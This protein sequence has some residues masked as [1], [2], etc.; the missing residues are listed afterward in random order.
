MD[1]YLTVAVEAAY[2]AGDIII[3]SMGQFDTVQAIQKGLN[4]WITAV[5]HA[6]EKVIIETLL[7]TYPNH[8]ILAEESGLQEGNAFTWIIDPLDGTRNYVHGFPQFAVSIG[9][10]H[11]KILECGVIYDPVRKDLYTAS[12][13]KGAQLNY[14]PIR[15]SIKEN[16][17]GSLVSSAFPLYDRD[18]NL[19]EIP[20][21]DIL[22]KVFSEGSDVR[23]IGSAALSLAHVATGQLDGFWESHLQPWDI[24]A[25]ALIVQEAGGFVSDFVG[26]NQFL[27]SGNIVAGTCHVHKKLLQIIQQCILA[28]FQYESPY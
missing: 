10:I 11:N 24:A 7:N 28:S 25:G 18:A 8:G 3:K 16:L 21:I 19:H 17:Q 1:P 14:Q 2:R 12:R 26:G 15:V 22:K 5:D 27:K 6:A 23:R 13:G 20:H 9:L 4:D